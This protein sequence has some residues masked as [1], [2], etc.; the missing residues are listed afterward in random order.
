MSEM[1][2]EL[3]NSAAGELLY[4]ALNAYKDLAEDE[5]I[6]AARDGT[7][8]YEQVRYRVGIVDGI[9][10]ALNALDELSS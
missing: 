3:L 4:E 9:Q 7:K 10:L 2:R 1:T 5:V 6:K 8:P